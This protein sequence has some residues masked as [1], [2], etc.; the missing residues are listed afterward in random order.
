MRKMEPGGI[1]IYMQIYE[2][3]IN[4]MLKKASRRKENSKARIGRIT[5]TE[6]ET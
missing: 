3:R 2:K 6:D 4:L 5:V 1:F